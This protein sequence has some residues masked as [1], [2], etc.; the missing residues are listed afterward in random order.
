MRK[1]TIFIVVACLL[2]FG[3]TPAYASTPPLPHA[4]YGD[5]TRNGSP[6]PSSTQVEARGEGVLTGIEGNPIT[7][8]EV[9]KYGGPGAL[10]QKLIVQGDI[11]EGATITFYVNGKTQVRLTP[12][13]AVRLLNLTYQLLYLNDLRPLHRQHHQPP[14]ILGRCPLR[15]LPRH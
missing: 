11:E 9:G 4:F 1:A 8:N 10:D 6:A 12:L 13:I 7:T 2:V 15:R 14:K 5:L 3:A